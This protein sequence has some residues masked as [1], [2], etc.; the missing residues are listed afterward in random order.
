MGYVPTQQNKYLIKIQ[1]W[2]R[3]RRLE[4]TGFTVLGRQRGREIVENLGTVVKFVESG[5]EVESARKQCGPFIARQEVVVFPRNIVTVDEHGAAGSGLI[6]DR[7]G[8]ESP[9]GAVQEIFRRVSETEPCDGKGEKSDEQD[10]CERSNEVSVKESLVDGSQERGAEEKSTD[11]SADVGGIRY[12]RVSVDQSVDNDV[13]GGYDEAERASNHNSEVLGHSPPVDQDVR[14]VETDQCIH[15]SRGSDDALVNVGKGTGEGAESDA[16]LVDHE[17]DDVSVNE[18]YW[19][20]EDELDEDVRGEVRVPDVRELVSEQSPRLVASIFALGKVRD[21]F[22]VKPRGP[23]DRRR[24]RHAAIPSRFPACVQKK[25]CNLESGEEKNGQGIVP[26]L[27]VVLDDDNGAR[28][29]DEQSALGKHLHGLVVQSYVGVVRSVEVS[30]HV[31]R[32]DASRILRSNDS[33]NHGAT[34]LAVGE[35]RRPLF[36]HRSFEIGRWR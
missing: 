9:K 15:S 10:D 21:E 31:S 30:K 4:S 36:H 17:D 2:A 12:R 3:R 5:V 7:V 25:R 11:V 23:D 6:V 32:R 26:L 13:D 29:V 18:F 28:H 35:Y 27:V 24:R 16:E 1:I 34:V 14:G 20:S 19:N 33:S 8:P 22:V